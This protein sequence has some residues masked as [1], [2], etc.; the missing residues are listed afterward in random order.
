[1]GTVY[2]DGPWGP[3]SHIQWGA[4]LYDWLGQGE[5]FTFHWKQQAGR[6]LG[7]RSGARQAAAE[8]S[9]DAAQRAQCRRNPEADGRRQAAPDDWQGGLPITYRIGPGPVTLEMDVANDE[10]VEPMRSV[11]GVIRGRE[12]PEKLVILGNHLDAWI[13]G[14]VDPVER[15]GGDPRDRARARARP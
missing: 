3:D 7:R 14:A 11:I 8:D 1:M 12:E 5:P 13:Y 9:L 10:R 15:H 2:P 4:I 6:Q